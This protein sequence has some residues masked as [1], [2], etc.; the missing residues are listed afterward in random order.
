MLYV[1]IQDNDMDISCIRHKL[2]S[3]KFLIISRMLPYK[4]TALQ[5]AAAITPYSACCSH[6]SDDGKLDFN[7]PGKG[8][9]N[10]NY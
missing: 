8:I 7:T 3:R 6:G 9:D 2:H 5:I 4:I 1:C 10:H